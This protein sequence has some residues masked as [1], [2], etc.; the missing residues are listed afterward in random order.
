[1]RWR[2]GAGETT[3][4]FLTPFCSFWDKSEQFVNK[5]WGRKKWLCIQSVRWWLRCSACHH[6]LP[7]LATWPHT[8]FFQA[9][10]R[11]ALVGYPKTNA[12]CLG[13][14]TRRSAAPGRP[15]GLLE[16][17]MLCTTSPYQQCPVKGNRFT[18]HVGQ[19][20]GYR[21]KGLPGW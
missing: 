21:K 14:E 16:G 11:Q 4:T 17:P 15:A 19:S 9:E 5:S 10:G 1:M 12:W 18:S 3:F 7:H 8:N 6:L 20:P 2:R 13:V